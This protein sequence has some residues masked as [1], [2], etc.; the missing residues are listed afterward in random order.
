MEF[1]VYV[2]SGT[3]LLYVIVSNDNEAGK[4]N[5]LNPNKHLT[6]IEQE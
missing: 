6:S 2:Y 1:F 5:V 3:L 4:Y